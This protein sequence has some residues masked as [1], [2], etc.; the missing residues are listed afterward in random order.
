MKYVVHQHFHL[1]TYRSKWTNKITMPQYA[2]NQPAGFKNQIETIA[3]VGVSTFIYY[4]FFQLLIDKIRPE[5]LVENTTQNI[6]LRL[7]SLRSLL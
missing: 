5:E 4:F 2:K 1:S 6:Y 3:I 7:G